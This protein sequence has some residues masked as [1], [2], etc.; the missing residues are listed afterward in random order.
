MVK[1]RAYGEILRKN[2]ERLDIVNTSHPEAMW[3]KILSEFYRL[4]SR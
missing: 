2:E 1:R 3:T 4:Q